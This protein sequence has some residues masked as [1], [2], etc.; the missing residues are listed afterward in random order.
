MKSRENVTKINNSNERDEYVGFVSWL[1][2]LRS[3][4]GK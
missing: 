2:L 3:D 1:H 4:G